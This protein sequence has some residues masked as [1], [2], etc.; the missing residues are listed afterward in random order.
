MGGPDF[1]SLPHHCWIGFAGAVD[2]FC[3]E[4]DGCGRDEKESILGDFEK[5]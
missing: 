2:C 5:N 4:Y 1:C 3:W